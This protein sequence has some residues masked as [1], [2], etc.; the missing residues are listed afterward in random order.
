MALN[1]VDLTGPVRPRKSSWDSPQRD[2][3]DCNWLDVPVERLAPRAIVVR[4]V[5]FL[6]LGERLLNEFYGFG[7]EWSRHRSSNSRSIDKDKE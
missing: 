7:V 6:Q 2:Y 3:I 4:D 1:C 5:A